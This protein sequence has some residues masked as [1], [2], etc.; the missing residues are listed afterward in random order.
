VF[1]SLGGFRVGLCHGH[2]VVPWGDRDALAALQR[3]LDVD[4]LVTGHT[5]EFKVGWEDELSRPR[6]TQTR[7]RAPPPADGN[8]PNSLSL[9]PLL[10]RSSPPPPINPPKKAVMYEDRLQINPGSATGAYA[11]RGV[12]PPPSTA[13]SAAHEGEPRPSFVLMDLD[14]P[15][16]TVYVYQLTPAGAVKVERIEFTKPAAASAGAGAGGAAGA[17]APAAATASVGG[18][19]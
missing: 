3:Q 8:A 11:P 14:A 1:P 7:A 6:C 5:H 2:Q 12:A 4:I 19:T 18:A 13:D 15:R 16:A 9:P 10:P 17:A